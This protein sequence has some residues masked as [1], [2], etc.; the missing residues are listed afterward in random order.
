MVSH[1]K[2]TID[3]LCVNIRK[4]NLNGFKTLDF[5]KLTKEQKNKIEESVYVMIVEYKH[6]PL[7]LDS[8]IPKE[9]Y[10]IV[11]DEWHFCLQ[12]EKEIRESTLAR[13][14]PDLNKGQIANANKSQNI[15]FSPKYRSFCKKIHKIVE[16]NI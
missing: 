7:E 2:S 6:T 14:L 16:D 5:N 12:M 10:K 1:P 11:E 15:K 3:K 9:L 4:E 8:S 13:L